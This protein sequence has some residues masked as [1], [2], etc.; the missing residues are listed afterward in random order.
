MPSR[1]CKDLCNDVVKSVNTNLFETSVKFSI[2]KAFPD[3]VLVLFL[4]EKYTRAVAEVLACEMGIVSSQNYVPSEK[5]YLLMS[6]RDGDA[7]CYFLLKPFREKLVFVDQNIC[8][9][10]EMTTQTK[11]RDSSSISES[12]VSVERRIFVLE[13]NR[14]L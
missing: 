2:G 7:F 5:W 1:E 13:E 4:N 3:T 11:D 12:S 9:V 6:H 14:I 8:I 10:E